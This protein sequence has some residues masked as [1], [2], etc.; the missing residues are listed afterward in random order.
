MALHRWFVLGSALAG[1][2]LGLAGLRDA[3]GRPEGARP[4]ASAPAAP[5]PAPPRPRER[6]VGVLVADQ[7]VTLAAATEGTVESVRVRPGDA[8]RRGEVIAALDTR[9][10]RREVAVV[11]ASA[12]S[13][14]AEVERASVDLAEARDALARREA[15][16]AQGLSSG[17]DLAKASFAQRS[18]AARVDVARARAAEARARVE[19]LRGAIRDAALTAPFDGTVAARFVDPGATVLRASPVVRVIGG[20]EPRLRVGV[21]PAVAARIAPG[22]P[23]RAEIGGAGVVL[24]GSVE[25]IAPEIDAS[26]RL[27]LVEARLRPEDAAR[28]RALAGESARVEIPG[29]AD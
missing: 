6:F 5:R 25:A 23:V 27:I 12:R 2:G 14:E 13:A 10:A 18:A 15:L 9:A 28:A 20:G 8:V 26:A 21:R 7:A 22:A 17:E 19:A 11:E 4:A 29:A 1:A 3:R 16:H 24:E